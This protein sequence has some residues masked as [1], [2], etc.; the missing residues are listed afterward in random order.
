MIIEVLLKIYNRFYND[1]FLIIII[2]HV[3]LA[4]FSCNSHWRYMQ[5][6]SRIISKGSGSSARPPVSTLH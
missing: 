5:H 4:N 2:S 6:W 3:S 1:R